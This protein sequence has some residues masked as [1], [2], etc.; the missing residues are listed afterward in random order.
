[1]D[2]PL[3]PFPQVLRNPL[4]GPGAGARSPGLTVTVQGAFDKDRL[5][6]RKPH[7]LLL[8][9]SLRGW[10]RLPLARVLVV[11]QQVKRLSNVAA[12][13]AREKC[14]ERGAQGAGGSWMTHAAGDSGGC[15]VAAEALGEWWR[16]VSGR[17]HRVSLH[18][19]GKSIAIS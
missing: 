9:A 2:M 15:K 3:E 11:G 10:D 18:F 14:R 19:T 7:T 5:A 16:S 13:H 8:Q 17:L 12:L 4:R 1:M 6:P